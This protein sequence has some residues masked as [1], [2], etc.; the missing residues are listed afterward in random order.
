M[1]GGVA[2]VVGGGALEVDRGDVRVAFD[3]GF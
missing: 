1:G 2:A 3:E